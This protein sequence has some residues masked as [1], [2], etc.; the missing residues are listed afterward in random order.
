MTRMNSTRSNRPQIILLACFCF[1]L[2]LGAVAFAYDGHGGWLQ[3]STV[4]EKQSVDARATDVSPTHPTEDYS[5]GAG[6]M[7][8]AVQSPP[9]QVLLVVGSTT[10]IEGDAAIKA[11]LEGLGF[12]V[13]V[14]DAPGSVTA[15]AT[16]K[17]LVVVS[18]SVTSADVGTKFRD[19][20]VPVLVLKVPIFGDMQMTGPTLGT[21]YD[22]NSGYTQVAITNPSHPMAAGLT[23]IVSVTT[24][25]TVKLNWGKPAASAVKVATL[26][27]D[28]AKYA[29]F[30]YES[31]VMMN[32]MS[33]PARR[34]GMFLWRDMPSVLTASGWAIFDAAVR[35]DT[36]TPLPQALLVV[37][38]TPLNAGDA[39]L[40]ARLEGLGLAVLVK[41]AAIT[42]T[43]DAT[44]KALVVVSESVAS[45]DVGAKFRDVA[46][47]VLVLEMQIFDDMQM[48]GPTFNTD[49]GLDGGKTQVIITNASH[50]L[51]AR[52]SG[53]V[54]VTNSA[55]S[56]C[57]GRPTLSAARV[58]SMP[59]DTT[60][61]TVFGY[62]A[63]AVMNG[64]SAPARRVGLF[65]AAATP[66]AL[67]GDGWALFDA[68]VR[69]D[70]SSTAPLAYAGGPYSAPATTNIQFDG[71]ASYDPDGTLVDYRWDFGDGQSG[72]GVSPSHAYASSGS[73]TVT[74]TVTDNVG[75]V[76]RAAAAVFVSNHPPVANA[77]GPY[78]GSAGASVQMSGVNSSDPDGSVAG[79]AWDFGD[80]TSGS[81]P[82]PSHTYT[83]EGTYNLTLTVTDDKGAVSAANVSV[84]IGPPS[85]STPGTPAPAPAKYS[86]S[87]NGTT[88]YAKVPNSDSL[89]ITTPFTVEAWVKTNSASAQQGIVERYNW[90]STDDGGF[91]LR[92]SGGKLLFGTVRNSS[93]YDLVVGNTPVT[94]GVWHHVAGVFDGSEL[95]L[96]LDGVL[97]ASKASTLSPA[98]GTKSLKIGA[99]GDNGAN[100]FDGLIDDVRLTGAVRY[101]SRFT[102]ALNLTAGGLALEADGT[103]CRGAWNFDGQSL[104]DVSG[105]N[106]HATLLGGAAFSTELKSLAT[107]GDNVT[108]TAANHVVLKFDDLPP[109]TIVNQRYPDVTFSAFGGLNVVVFNAAS[110]GGIGSSPPN[111]IGVVGGF[112]NTSVE[113]DFTKP[114]DNLSFLITG[115]DNDSFSGP[116]A[117][118]DVYQNNVYKTTRPVNGIGRAGNYT[119]L[120]I[121]VGNEFN[122]VT[123]VVI[124]HITD[125]NGIGFDDFVFDLPAPPPT[126]TPTPLPT[127]VPT[128]PPPPPPTNLQ[129]TAGS[130]RVFLTWSASPGATG[131]N[132]KRSTQNNEPYTF[133]NIASGVVATS[134]TDAG[135]EMGFKYTYVVTAIKGGSESGG[136]NL[137]SAVLLGCSSEQVPAARPAKEEFFTVGWTGTGEVTDRDGFVMRDIALNGRYMAD[138]VS[139][140]YFYVKTDKMSAPQRGE[141]TY[142]SAATQM[143]TRLFSYKKFTTTHIDGSPSGQVF[144]VTYLVD[145]LTPASTGCLFLTQEYTFQEPTYGCE[146]TET[147]PCARFY[148][149]VKYHF[150]GGLGHEKLESINVAERHHNRVDRFGQNSVAVFRDCDSIRTCVMT[151]SSFVFQDQMNPVGAEF[152]ARVIENGRD[153]GS[154][155]NFHETPNQKMFVEPGIRPGMTPSPHILAGGCPECVHLHWRWGRAVPAAS[156]YGDGHALVDPSGRQDLD[157]AVVRYHDRPEEVHPSTDYRALLTPHP[158][159][160][161]HYV[162]PRQSIDPRSPRISPLTTL[163]TDPDE[164]VFWYSATAHD[165]LDG[166]LFTNAVFFNP[167][168]GTPG[169]QQV[170]ADIGIQQGE[171]QD[172]PTDVTFGHLFVPGE[173]EISRTDPSPIGPLPAGY[174]TYNNVAYLVDT[175]AVVSGPHEVTFSLPGVTNQAA[176]GNL[177]VLHAEQDPF[178]PTKAVWVD[179]TVL[180]PDP[181][182]PD[183]A[184]RTIRARVDSLGYFTLA[185]M[186][187]PPS[188][189]ATDLSVAI[190]ATPASVVAGNPLTYNVTVT[191]N[192]PQTAAGAGAVLT[193]SPDVTFL[194]AS[195]AQAA[196]KFM[197]GSVYCKLG[198]ISVGGSTSFGVVVTP[199]EV[200]SSFPPAGKTV[201]SAVT[202]GAAGD[203]TNATNNTAA[204]S[205]TALPAPGAAPVVS[206]TAPSGNAV[207][208][209]PQ[210]INVTA[211]ASDSDGTVSRVDFYDNGELI[212]T[213]APAGANQYSL[214]WNN[215]GFGTH[216]LRAIA[217]DNSGRTA[218]SPSTRILVNGL[219]NVSITSPSNGALITPSTDVTVTIN[220]A[221]P[222]QGIAKVEVYV[223]AQLL[224]TA[225]V[226]GP[227][228]YSI[229]WSDIRNGNYSL[230][231][232]VTDGT[233]ITTTSLPVNVA[234]TRAPS[235]SITSPA[236]GSTFQSS[237][238]VHLRAHANDD[239]SLI[240]RVDYYVNGTLIGSGHLDASGDCT[241]DWINPPD[242][243]YSLT[244]VAVDDFG[245]STRSSA[246]NVSVNRPAPVQGEFTWVDDGLP[247]GA[248]VGGEEAWYWVDANPAPI[249]GLKSHQSKIAAG[250][251]QHYFYG[252]TDKLPVNAGDRLFTYVF[253]DRDHLPTEI[254]LQW[255]AGGSW[256]HRAYWGANAINDMG[257]PGTEARRYMGPLPPSGRWIRLEVPADMV[258]LDGK[259]VDGMAFT[260]ADGR[261]TWDRAGKAT[262]PA[263]APSQGDLTWV[264]DAVPGGAVTSNVDDEW[265]WR[266]DRNIYPI[267]SGQQS[268]ET[269][270]RDNDD[271]RFRSHSFDGV[272]SQNRMVVRQG[273]ILFTYVYLYPTNT[274]DEIMLE[275]KDGS[276]WG[277][278]AYWGA[279]WIVDRGVT[280]TESRRYMGGLPATGRWVRLEVPAS[281]V[282]LEGRTVEGMAFSVYRDQ[283]NPRVAWDASGRARAPLTILPQLHATTPLYR[284][285]GTANNGY[286]Y[287]STNDIGRADQ[288]VQRV[289]FY[290]FPAQAAGTVAL[291]RFRHKTSQRYF[292]TTDQN[293]PSPDQW[294]YEG[295]T[296]YVY[297]D[298]S[299]PGTVPLHRFRGVHD[300]FFTTD[301]Q[302]GGNLGYTYDG[303]ACYVHNAQSDGGP[304]PIDDPAFFVRQH[305]YDFLNREPDPG[306]FNAWL[307]ILNGCPAGNTSC[308]RVEVSSAFFRSPE[309]LDRGYFILRFYEVAL[310]RHP[311]YAEFTP[312]LARTTGFLTPEQLE[313]NKAAFVV[314]FTARQEFRSRYDQLG[315]TAYVDTL[316]ATAGVTLANRNAWIVALDTGQKSRAQVLREIAESPEV[317]TKFFNKAF[318]VMQYFGY[319]RRD[320]DIHYLEWI[321]TLDSTGDYR[322]MINGFVNSL[323]YRQRFAP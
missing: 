210:N 216:T 168:Y 274:P 318:V 279:N 314:D 75:A 158:E 92:L 66:T 68:A 18:G 25:S 276:G 49:Y 78:T 190:N 85:Q 120:P 237:D 224:G 290:I 44:S 249:N 140:P 161:R 32:G 240:D 33:A 128:P 43:A 211:T 311:F 87:L 72:T 208:V 287:Y 26:P 266:T 225:V 104:Q 299:T 42:T 187:Q 160:I 198:T 136:S 292:Y 223:D 277:H 119:P 81:G 285:F 170:S 7:P 89:N 236:D 264:D 317:G 147:L 286:Y 321:Q 11:R 114:V 196:C 288:Q 23:G 4:F 123:T 70:T 270:F 106:N 36:S 93:T 115:T 118:V 27:T 312:D 112:F 150:S 304:N 239:D 29:L 50:P 9:R 41:D 322:T 205:T 105:H 113:V 303:I 124:H 246:V 180:A 220:A 300:Y 111:T 213:G 227:N 171:A 294:N 191:N 145:R 283:K 138:S 295:V 143:R 16:G 265:I 154:W 99:E 250:M 47:P 241:F 257:A 230:S 320:P 269:Y 165:S 97:D 222:S 135:L 309:F 316:L 308:D 65:L 233:G 134:F 215:V 186:T 242:G 37:G 83:A 102:P 53:T 207:Y 234:A 275:W 217:T 130:E 273:D 155:D 228:Q 127:P 305:Y 51:A 162:N 95:R 323:E 116:L 267:Y 117:L 268:H 256:E 84:T 261:A 251:H 108:A 203:D 59:G 178:D 166:S 100:T 212:G 141:L 319:L 64:M 60:M 82:T 231:A 258:G 80:N 229:P 153:I 148:A 101:S 313:A 156:R 38:S 218:P 214:A 14:K 232:V 221:H 262:L 202:V 164:V 22:S 193:L 137:A 176:F 5:H 254:M 77:G 253:L 126:P 6:S 278:R 40:K 48:T 71:G 282:G 183:F 243:I 181:K 94:V 200:A 151:A 189:A 79:Y 172:G 35:W 131:Y 74:L 45:A 280:G 315:N 204:A 62:E 90:L 15:D 272:P 109:G 307:G 55:A 122:Q 188:A 98:A 197:D 13:V 281:Y 199:N 129:A 58:G 310:G 12:T 1:L 132:I 107:A 209:G 289:Q 61:S 226:T 31:G 255:R 20:A 63:G 125:G 110:V 296:G 297:G 248:S 146:P 76:G 152:E 91:A 19:V 39:A 173:L 86:L 301:Q 284:F 194:S 21:D 259:I 238:T 10:L 149:K 177:R 302:E 103:S 306:G 263:A 17:V 163:L 206:I 3:F 159:A 192:G 185:S 184:T 24:S 247:A 34:V 157:I 56:F 175:T 30:G 195:P 260:L 88:A 139:A 174:A 133:T 245:V 2:S 67:N 121:N 271:K 142:D 179:Q 52:R 69:W 252:A 54:T 291:H 298:G 46:V 8:L 201:S 73:Y 28:S 96:Y 244:A 235:V 182:A 169:P 167:E 293:S 219:A 144:S 57:W